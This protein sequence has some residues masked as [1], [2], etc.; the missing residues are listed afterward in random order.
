M[1]LRRRNDALSA[2]VE[3]TWTTASGDESNPFEW[4]IGA[5]QNNGVGG[6]PGRQNIVVL[7]RT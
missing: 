4:T 2:A 1:S 7:R 5:R 6:K 3:C